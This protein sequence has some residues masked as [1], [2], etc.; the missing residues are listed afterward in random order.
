MAIISLAITPPGIQTADTDASFPN[1]NNPA[2][3]YLPDNN[4]SFVTG[5]VIDQL[6]NLIELSF[7]G[8]YFPAINFTE[9]GGQSLAI[10][11]YPNLDSARVENTGRK[12]MIWTIRGVFTD[13]IYPSINESWIAGTLYPNTFEAVRSSLEDS[14]VPIKVLVHPN[15]GPVN[16]CVQSWKWDYIG[17]GPRD[18]VFMDMVFVETLA[19]N[20]ISATISPNNPSAQLSN[21]ASQLDSLVGDSPIPVQPPGMNLNGFFSNLSATVTNAVALPSAVI[22]S[23][24]APIF[25]AN[26]NINQSISAQQFYQNNTT[27]YVTG[28]NAGNLVANINVG[29]PAINYNYQALQNVYAAAFSLNTAQ[30]NNATQLINSTLAFLGNMVTYYTSINNISTAAIKLNLYLMMNQLQQIQQTLFQNSSQYAIQ[31]YTTQGATTL[32]QLS[33]LLN[34]S[35][36]QLLSLNPTL[37]KGLYIPASIPVNYFQA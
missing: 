4:N 19:D 23:I 15:D 13:N 34:N 18:G 14:S 12:P 25:S 6:S 35:V 2:I 24:N 29:L 17:T 10:H 16:V 30:H 31:Q 11:E 26:V 21:T 28:N 9:Q 1:A 32:I 33:S 27:S 8:T 37:N 36:T 20:Q 3:G 7:D 5:I 22:V